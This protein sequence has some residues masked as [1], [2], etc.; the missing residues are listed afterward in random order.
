MVKNIIKE[1]TDINSYFKSIGVKHTK[2]NMKKL[3]IDDLLKHDFIKITD[4][5]LIDYDNHGQDLI[6]KFT[7]NNYP[8]K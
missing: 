7:H 2:K 6:L 5:K 1:W 8:K 3:L 4:F